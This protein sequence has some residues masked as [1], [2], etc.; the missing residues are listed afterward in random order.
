MV[1]LEDMGTTLD[2]RL[3][4]MDSFLESED[5]TSAHTE[6]VRNFEV[7][8]TIGPAIVLSFERHF[9]GQWTRARTRVTSFPPYC[10]FVEELEG[11]FAGTRFAGLHRP[12]GTKTR[13]DIFGDFQ[14]QGKSPEETRR[15]WLAIFAKSHDE[16][17]ASLRR[18]RSR[19]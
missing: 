15:I 4:E 16:D 12:Q 11:V 6:D 13:V 18:F 10:R 19:K 17:L 5:H 3:E 8:E 7:V 14:C 2:I 9:D 1:Y